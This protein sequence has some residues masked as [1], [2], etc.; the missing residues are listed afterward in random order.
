MK[1]YRTITV[2]SEESG[3]RQKLEGIG[4]VF[5]ERPVFSRFHGTEFSIEK[6]KG[7]GARARMKAIDEL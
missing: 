5:T 1:P 2:Y 6:P 7:K 3:F 4:A